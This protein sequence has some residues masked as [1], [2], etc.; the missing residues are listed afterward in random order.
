MIL[1]T[2]FL[3]DFM[4]GKA[5][6]TAK[7]S[8]LE[9]QDEPLMVTTPTIHEL[10]RGI[11]ALEKT[12]QQQRLK[13]LLQSTIILAMDAQTAECSGKIEGTLIKQGK[14]VEVEDCMI[15]GIALHHHQPI[16]TRDKD[17]HL[18]EGLKVAYY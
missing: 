8:E 4:Q 9:K 16:L 6:A 1:E 3:I 17:F 18:I 10:W 13:A 11:I 15:A 12:A 2:T 14:T 5:V 7:L